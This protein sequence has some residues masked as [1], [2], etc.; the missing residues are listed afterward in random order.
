MTRA[1]ARFFAGRRVEGRRVNR[2]ELLARAGPVRD[3]YAEHG[4][5]VHAA[6]IAFRVLVALVPLVLLSTALLGV[7]GL[8]DTWRDSIA[9]PLHDRLQPKVYEAI[10]F[11]V[12][13]ILRQPT[14]GLILLSS[15]LLVWQSTRGVRTVSRA[16]NTIHGVEEGRRWPRLALVTLGL[17]VAVAACLIAAAFTTIVGGRLGLLAS[18]LRWPAAVLLLGLAVGLLVR[19]APAEHPEPRWASVGSAVIVAGWLLLS[20][21]FGI[22]V[23]DVASYRS[24]TGTLLAFL[25]LTAYALGVSAVFL[26]GV[27]IDETARKG[28]APTRRGARSAR[29]RSSSSRRRRAD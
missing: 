28:R 24:A 6:A 20:V 5:A 4:L 8:R 26:V 11:V 23:R 15:A 19:Y 2:R 3:A 21:V 16:L 17:A 10:D 13:Q 1:Y 7:L 25:V 22:W 9:P 27:E 29:G 14:L 18:I 12:E